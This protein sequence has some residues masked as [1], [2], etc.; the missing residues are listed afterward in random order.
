MED[1][2]GTVEDW[3]GVVGC[4][5]ITPGAI[6]NQEPAQTESSDFRLG[7]LHP[8]FTTATT[9]NTVNS[10]ST[11][12]MKVVKVIIAYAKYPSPILP[13][14]SENVHCSSLHDQRVKKA[15]ASRHR[16]SSH[17]LTE[18]MSIRRKI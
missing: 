6:K 10:A 17:T 3:S 12:P 1:W 7:L 14:H 18:T 4:Y 2:F 16:R 5:A 13:S 11:Q 8:T 15:F 9:A